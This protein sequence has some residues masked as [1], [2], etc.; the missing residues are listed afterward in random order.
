M[1]YLVCLMLTMLM[2][3][4]ALAQTASEPVAWVDGNP[5]YGAELPEL[6]EPISVGDAL[7]VVARDGEQ[8][9]AIQG[10]I[11]QVCQKKGCWL[12]LTEGDR[13]LRVF[14]EDH[15]YF[16][17]V[18]TQGEALALGRISEHTNSE[19]FARHL[20]EDAGEEAASIDGEQV[21][22]RFDATSILLLSAAI[23]SQ[24]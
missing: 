15:S 8:T 10:R 2:P 6:V 23:P 4:Y 7:D 12:M 21:E 22:Y 1:R 14:T 5:V 9:L 11:T 16:L 17:P 24:P 3:A 18:D 13:A 20:A 19:A